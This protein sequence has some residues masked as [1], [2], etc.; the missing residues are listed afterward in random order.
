MKHW[1]LHLWLLINVVVMGYL[2]FTQT[3]SEIMH[4][5]ILMIFLLSS[6]LLKSKKQIREVYTKDIGKSGIIFG[7]S[8]VA[9]MIYAALSNVN[10]SRINTPLTE[11]QV[12]YGLTG[13]LIFVIGFYIFTL[14]K[15][16]KSEGDKKPEELEVSGE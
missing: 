16:L 14:H 2:L 11:T 4:L 3:W 8:F 6:F 13:M 12:Q 10:K 5:F 7:A 9:I 15:R 1:K